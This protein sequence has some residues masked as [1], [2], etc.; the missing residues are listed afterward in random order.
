M[1]KE[2]MVFLINKKQIF[3]EIDDINIHWINSDN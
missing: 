2:H 3:V 1:N